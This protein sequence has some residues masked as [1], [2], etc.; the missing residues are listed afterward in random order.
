MATPPMNAMFSITIIS[1]LRVPLFILGLVAF[2]YIVVSANS[3]LSRKLTGWKTIA[4]HFPMMENQQAGYTFEGRTAIIGSTSYT[5]SINIR[6]TDRGVCLYPPFARRN[7]C[8]IPWSAIRW[9]S[10]DDSIHVIVD[11]ERRLEFFLPAK[12][13]SIVQANHSESSAFKVNS[14]FAAVNAAIADKATPRWMAWIAGRA[15]Q[16]V[17][18]EVEK[19]KAHQDEGV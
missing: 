8:L 19:R 5:G 6:I 10:A 3:L 15:M 7:P 12:A 17:E 11:Y 1:A 2:A 16:S 14:P 18:K 13:L 9:V 4:G